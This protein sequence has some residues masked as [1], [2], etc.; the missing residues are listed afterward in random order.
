MRFLLIAFFVILAPACQQLPVNIAATNSSTLLAQL[1]FEEQAYSKK[2]NGFSNDDPAG[3][4]AHLPDLSFTHLQSVAEG[5]QVILTKLKEI[6]V[7]SLSNQE[8]INR[9]LLIYKLQRRVDSFEFK[10]YLMPLTSEYGF[11]A[12]LT[13]IVYSVNFKTLQD[14][15]DYLSRLAEVPRYFEQ[16]MN[17]M[18]EGIKTG[19]TQPKAVLTGY[20]QSISAFIKKDVT[21]S[22]FYQPFLSLPKS[23]SSIEQQQLQLQ[24]KQLLTNAVM[25]SYQRYYDF[26]VADYMPNAR[27]S[28][29]A[30]A[31]PKGKA[32]YQNQIEYYTTLE[33]SPE[34][35]Y[36]QGLAEV[37][38]IDAEMRA[39]IKKVN[40][41]G[42]FK[43]FIEYLRTD[44][45]FYA[46]SAKELLMTASYIAKQMDAKLPQLFHLLP[47]TPYGVASVPANIA[48]KYTTGRYSPPQRDDQP[49]SYWVNTYRLDRRPLY[50]LEAL[51]FHEAV[52]G[53]H[54]QGSI[55]KEMKNVPAFRNDLYISAF[56]EGWGLYS[57]YLGKEVG[58][59]QDPY[60]EF[61]RLT[62]EMWRACRLVIDTGI[63]HM[64]WTRQQA[65]NYLASHTALSLH[66]VTTEVDRYISWPAQALSYKLGELTI[67][68]LRTKAEQALGSQFDIREFHDRVLANGSI[69]LR[70]LEQQID[71]YIKQKQMKK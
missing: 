70:V 21:K 44:P 51:T 38:R 39:I 11:H 47:R 55:A 58:F 28:L 56:G 15:K 42:D 45:K 27:N 19:Y 68:R 35:I 25:P 54:L 17:W 52:P 29:A 37:K 61:G 26:M 30:E 7:D 18:R 65:I 2:V 14:Y 64:G 23:F 16:Q 8:N 33:L 49:G 69:P 10:E 3:K 4:N 40:F 48:P 5:Y 41:N 36:Q 62:Y 59:Y 12:G 20:E 63:H 53:H 1:I 22:V 34:Q 50:V 32:Y 9:Q 31:L 71:N 43:A 46:K 24:A 13:D 6:N 60:S 57:E 67:K 66:N